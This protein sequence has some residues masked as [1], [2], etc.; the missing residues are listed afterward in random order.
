VTSG[1][2]AMSMPDTV[3][4]V[5]QSQRNGP[6]IAAAAQLW[7]N[8]GA[9]VLDL[10]YGRGNF[11]T[12]YRPAY[13][14]TNDL[15]PET[16]AEHNEDF[17]KTSWPGASFDVVVFDPPYIARGGVDTSTVPGFLAAYG[18]NDKGKTGVASSVEAVQELMRLGIAEAVR[19]ARPGG[20]L[21]VKC[22]DFIYSG[23]YQ[24]IRH[25]VVASALAAGLEQ[26]D[27]FVHYSGTGP[28][29]WERQLHS[30]R[31]HSFLCIFQKGRA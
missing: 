21:M 14:V 17:C 23:R 15:D 10:T 5:V 26:V 24:A 13:L 27:E 16:A 8:D 28:G 29:S 9:Q 18:L 30:R 4:S 25:F 31:A 2:I 22:M 19:V 3:Q 20:V 7:I 6:L 11:W 1:Q 12:E